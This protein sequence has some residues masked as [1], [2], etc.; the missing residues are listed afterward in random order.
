MTSSD[1]SL[2]RLV[3]RAVKQKHFGRVDPK[4]P[5]TSTKSK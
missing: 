1:N 2:A 5:N 4:T 3:R